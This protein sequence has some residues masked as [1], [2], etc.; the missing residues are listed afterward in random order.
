M[1]KIIPGEVDVFVRIE[2]MCGRRV[3]LRHEVDVDR[4]GRWRKEKGRMFRGS[5]SLEFPTSSSMPAADPGLR[6]T[7][8]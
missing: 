7:H 8:L 6:D 4:Q 3:P 1:A 5:F 2:Y